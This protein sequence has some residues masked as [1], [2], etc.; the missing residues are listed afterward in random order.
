MTRKTHLVGAWPGHSPEHAMETALEHLA[1]HLVRMTDG[2]T[3]DRRLWITPSIDTFR[4]NPDVEKIKDGAWT[5]YDDAA[6]FRVRDGVTLKSDNIR[7]GYARAFAGSFPAFKVLRERFGRPDLIFQVGVPAPVDLSVTTFGEAGFT[8]PSIL[9]AT[10][11][12]ATGQIR[13]IFEVAGDEVVFQLETVTAL[14]AI[15]QAPDDE[16]PK[17]SAQLADGFLDLVSRAPQG[18][19]YGA[20]LCLGDFHHKAYGKM[21][22]VRPLVL[23]AHELA[24]RWP[25]G[26]FLDYVHAPFAAAAEPPIPD[27][28]FYAPLSDLALPA[29]TRFV[30]GFIHEALD[31]QQNRELLERI[32]RLVGHEVDVAAACG[33][34]RRPTTDQAW[35]AMRK[36]IALIEDVP[37]RGGRNRLPT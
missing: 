7:L 26:R 33:L 19:R 2:E 13:E 3:G 25:D 20:H 15:A 5:D 29:N 27:P 37:V 9:E 36:A 21:R 22:D 23:F 8:D 18:S 24:R 1:P 16:Q 34:G 4:A 28:R 12:A 31:I 35:D 30:A 10:T 11:E 32:E 14:V 6:Q 17:V